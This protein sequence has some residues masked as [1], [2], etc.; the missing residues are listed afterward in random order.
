MKRFLAYG[1]IFC[2]SLTIVLPIPTARASS[3]FPFVFHALSVPPGANQVATG[4]ANVEVNTPSQD[5]KS[6]QRTQFETSVAV[7]GSQV[8]VGFNDSHG[9]HIGQKVTGCFG[10]Y[11]YSSD[12]GASFTDGGCPPPPKGGATIGDPSLVVDPTGAFYYGQVMFD[13]Q[14]NEFIGVSKSTDGGK[15]WSQPVNASPKVRTSFQDKDWLSVGINPSHSSQF[16]LYAAWTNI[17]QAAAIQL[18]RSTDGGKTWSSPV[19]LQQAPDVYGA[20]TIEDPDTGKAYAFWANATAGS[21]LNI[22]ES[23]S[24][25]GGQTWSSAQAI[26]TGLIQSDNAIVQCSGSPQAVIEFIPG[27]TTH[28]AL[29][30]TLPQAA[31]DPLTHD[32]YVV[33]DEKAGNH[34]NIALLSSSDGSTW[35]TQLVAPTAKV[36][37]QPSISADQQGVHLE[38]YQVNRNG[39]YY[40]AGINGSHAVPPVF[41]HP[42]KVSN[43]TLQPPVTNPSSDPAVRAC[44]M[45]DYNKMA[46]NG[47]SITYIWTD[48]RHFNKSGQDIWSAT[49]NG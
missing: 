37:F 29:N 32:I 31:I 12:G 49:T 30:A 42:F 28:V 47:Q 26:A 4:L 18:S 23:I 24:T 16:I 39:T 27:D 35:Q 5:R 2:L 3:S 36:Q 10:G 38:Y 6:L 41:D 46:S 25:D 22:E 20:N 9:L 14:G 8:V 7:F 15:T 33:I 1:V 40:E 44:A 43:T 13:G 45:G 11:A 17:G 21:S 19:D 34:I 48:T